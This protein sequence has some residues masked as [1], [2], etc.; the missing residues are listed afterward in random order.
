MDRKKAAEQ[1]FR[2]TVAANPALSEAAGAWDRIAQA[3]KII[4]EHVVAEDLLER[5]S[6]FNS[7]LFGFARD[8]LRA[9]EEQPK[10]NGERLEEYRESRRASLEFRLF[11]ET[12]IYADL[13]TLKLAD[14]LTWLAE[15]GLRT[16]RWCRRS[17]PA[18]RRASAPPRS[19][20][21]PSWPPPP[22]VA[23]YTR[24]PAGH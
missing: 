3:Q 23:S 9:A 6:G 8:L 11:S 1:Q 15:A 18:S 17:S 22:R 5:G 12:P 24:R 19:C 10:P 21:A 13:E 14:S 7:V 4:A 16:H 2:A 20:A